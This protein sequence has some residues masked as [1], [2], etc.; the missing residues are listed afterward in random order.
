MCR[1]HHTELE[2]SATRVGNTS[3]SDSSE[4]ESGVLRWNS[5]IGV[6]ITIMDCKQ[7]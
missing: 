4:K 1:I 5:L 2:G 6:C 3:L 7:S